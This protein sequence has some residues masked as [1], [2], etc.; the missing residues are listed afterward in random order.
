MAKASAL[1]KPEL[2]RLLRL[3]V[4]RSERISPSFQRVTLGGG[5]IS[6]FVPMGWDQ[7]FRLF[8]PTEGE[9]GL[10]D[11]PDKVNLRGYLRYLRIE[12]GKRPVLR[13]YTVRAFRGDE[14]DV[15]FV[16]HGSAADGTA[17]PASAWAETCRPGD[18]VALVDEGVAFNAER[19]TDRVLLVADETGVPAVAGILE[20]LPAEATGIAVIEVPTPDDRFDL[21][22]AEGIEM[23]WLSRSEGETPGANALEAVR[24]LTTEDVP[25]VHAFVVGE[26]ALV[27]GARRHLV[28]LDVP[29]DRISFVG[30]WKLGAAH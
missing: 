13:N 30:Y 9:V 3:E 21:T 18:Q 26:Q 25:D 5:S 15:D 8:I 11:L 10:D 28:S 23:R 2:Q 20:S 19:G 22:H 27:Q 24:F 29:K 17:G 16:L 7:W 4:V 6:E 1:V 14:L 12:K